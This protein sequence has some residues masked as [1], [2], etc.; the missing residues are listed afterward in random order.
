MLLP[1][2]VYSGNDRDLFS[3]AVP[4]GL[5]KRERVASRVVD[6]AAPGLAL[7]PDP[8]ICRTQRTRNCTCWLRKPQQR[9]E[10]PA[11]GA[12]LPLPSGT[13]ALGTGVKEEYTSLTLPACGESQRTASEVNREEWWTVARVLFVIAVVYVM[14][15]LLKTTRLL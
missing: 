11:G 3:Q 5:V 1:L 7:A 2:T 10:R 14:Y 15:T 9:T 6:P 12:V 4:G 13:S 8:L